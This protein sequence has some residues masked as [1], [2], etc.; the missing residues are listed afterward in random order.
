MPQQRGKGSALLHPLRLQLLNLSAGAVFC[1]FH[2]P[3]G[4]RRAIS[5]CEVHGAAVYVWCVDV[6]AV[7][8]STAVIS[9]VQQQH[10]LGGAA[11]SWVLFLRV[12]PQA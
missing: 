7:I 9:R 11:A 3:G 1:C 10:C 6:R 8:G 4:A 5:G 2:F 12:L